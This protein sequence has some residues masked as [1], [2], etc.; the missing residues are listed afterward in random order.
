M[1]ASPP[2]FYM[3]GHGAAGFHFPFLAGWFES[4]LR[5]YMRGLSAGQ[6]QN[7]AAR[8]V[9]FR[10]LA[11]TGRKPPKKRKPVPQQGNPGP[12]PGSETAVGCQDPA[13]LSNW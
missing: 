6:R 11:S 3:P 8:A 9:K 10:P 4:A 1:G 13:H 5:L 12:T 7:D 2:S